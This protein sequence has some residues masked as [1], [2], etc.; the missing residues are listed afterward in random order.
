MVVLVE[1]IFVE[2]PGVFIVEGAGVEV[3]KDTVGERLVEI[4]CCFHLLHESWRGE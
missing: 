1:G 2:L 3:P 4:T